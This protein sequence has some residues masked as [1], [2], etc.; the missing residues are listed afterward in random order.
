M[1][2]A[3]NAEVGGTALGASADSVAG[4]RICAAVEANDE[5]CR[6]TG[7]ATANE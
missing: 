7:A 5:G 3:A 2:A 1:D 4:N 6:G